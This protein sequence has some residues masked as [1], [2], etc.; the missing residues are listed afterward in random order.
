MTKTWVYPGSSDRCALAAAAELAEVLVRSAD[1]LPLRRRSRPMRQARTA[2]AADLERRGG[3]QLAGR[4]TRCAV[5]QAATPGRS[6][7]PDS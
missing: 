4:G 6:L 7:E 2:L 3:M 1:A 5:E